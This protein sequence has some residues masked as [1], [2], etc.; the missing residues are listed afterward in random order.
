MVVQK[1]ET[2]LAPAL[3]QSE[4]DLA[5]LPKDNVAQ[6]LTLIARLGT[7]NPPQYAVF[8]AAMKKIFAD[9]G[10][11]DGTYTP[12]GVNTTLIQTYFNQALIAASGDPLRAR[13]IGN[14]WRLASF[15]QIGHYDN[16]TDIFTRSLIAFGGYLANL[17]Q[18]ALYPST[19]PRTMTLAK[20]ESLVIHFSGKPKVP[21][22]GFWSLTI[23]DG[24]G[25]LFGTPQNVYALGDRSVNMTFP[26]GSE[27]YG[28]EDR[29]GPFEILVQASNVPPPAK[30]TN[31]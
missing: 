21:E 28:S 23:Y 30:W 9:A 15:A 12:T 29:D 26:D 3:T 2:P 5:T 27:V 19:Q 8:A 7:R 24:S 17:P 16:G 20:N 22:N 25:Y 11:R 4:I 6:A 18:E 13:D 31:K 1:V 10:I 14:G